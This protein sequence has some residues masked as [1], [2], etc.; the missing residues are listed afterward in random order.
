MRS[1]LTDFLTGFHNRRYL[2]ARLT[3]ELARAQRAHQTVA[4]LMID[5]DH[6]KHYNDTY[7]HLAGDEVLKKVAEAIRDGCRRSTDLAAR[8]GGEEFA[9]VLPL[10][11]ARWP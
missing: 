2:H 6:F 5:V 10:T 4:C 3:E 9:A 11:P 7:G 1:G 8:Y